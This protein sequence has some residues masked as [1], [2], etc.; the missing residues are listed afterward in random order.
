MKPKAYYPVNLDLDGKLCLVVGGGDI[1]AHK[2]KALLAFGARVLVVSPEFKKEMTALLLS[3]KVRCIKRGY[4]KKDIKGVSLVIAATNVPSVN[5][6]IARHAQ[7]RNILINVVDVPKLCNFIVPSSL[8]R[9]PLTIAVSTGG[10]SPVL[11][12]HIRNECEICR[13]A[14]Y[15]TLAK[16]LGSIR[17]K[18]MNRYAT[19]AE[20]KGVYTRILDSEVI[21]L[22]KN[23]KVREAKALAQK[24]I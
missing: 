18:V 14:Y 17:A 20:R 16:M 8:K 23:N 6:M 3:R 22:L 5:K 24:L 11:A 1:A 4:Q 15:G 2:A 19:K 10:H 9:G 7:S 13:P 12:Q 21:N